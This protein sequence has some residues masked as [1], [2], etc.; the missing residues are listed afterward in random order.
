MSID[1]TPINP[2]FDDLPVVRLTSYMFPKHDG[3]MAELH[4]LSERVLCYPARDVAKL[5]HRYI[6]HRV[7]DAT[8]IYPAQL[9]K[10]M[11]A[12]EDMWAGWDHA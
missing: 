3:D 1:Y 7:Q 9:L 4:E 12:V 2:V 6:Y 8:G 11:N 5:A 10:S